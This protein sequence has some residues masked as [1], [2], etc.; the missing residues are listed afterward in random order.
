VTGIWR[1]LLDRSCL[2]FFGIRRSSITMSHPPPMTTMMEA[3]T[4]TTMLLHHLPLRPSSLEILK[5]AGYVTTANEL[6]AAQ[7]KC[8]ISTLAAELQVSSST[9]LS[10]VR[11][12]T[13][14]LLLHS[15][16]GN[17]NSGGGS[18]TAQ[19]ILD[20]RK[21]GRLVGDHKDHRRARPHHDHII[22]FCRALDQIL[23][24]G[25]PLGQVTE[26]VGPPGSGK[27]L[28]ATQLAVNT[29]MPAVFGGVDGHVIYIDTE[30]S[31]APERCCTLADHLIRHIR[32][33]VERRSKVQQRPPDRQHND[34]DHPWQNVTPADILARIHVYRTH[35][36]ADLV[37]VLDALDDEY[38]DDDHDLQQRRPWPK[39]NNCRLLVIDSIALPFRSVPPDVART[40]LLADLAARLTRLAT[41][42]DLAVVCINH[43]TTTTTNGMNGNNNNHHNSMGGA[44][45]GATWAHAIAN[46]LTVSM[47][48]GHHPHDTT[49]TTAATTTGVS[50][51]KREAILV[52][53]ARMPI[54]T[55]E[56]LVTEAGIR[57]TEYV[58]PPPPAPQHDHHH[59]RPRL[60]EGTNSY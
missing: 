56:F 47:A 12:V 37:A 49:T 20:E 40:R 45:L 9:A 54:A 30:G 32:A 2:V 8:S 25:I 6:L 3:E 27:T 33:G 29:T 55:A 28:L 15:G 42:Y 19:S 11:E 52:K 53:S 10:I 1:I 39:M 43:S 58:V 38:D 46:R 7:E 24:G 57:G 60:H 26:L 4:M 17:K 23:G 18:R 36:V 51:M 21:F 31:F 5:T 14:A 13:E 16:V 22:T 48:P 44:A 35:S 41:D 59:K 34:D 50:A